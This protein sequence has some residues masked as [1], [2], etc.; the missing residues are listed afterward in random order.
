[1]RQIN[2]L[3]AHNRMLESDL[4]EALTRVRASGWLV[5]GPEVEAFEREFADYCGI[6]HCI[7][8]ASG[9]D[10][11]E[12]ALRGLGVGPGDEVITAPNAGMYSSVA[13]L[14]VGATP[15]YA[16]IDPARSTICPDDAATRITSRTRALI[17]THLYG[18]MAKVRELRD[19]AMRNGFPLIEDCAQAHGAT[20]DGVRAGAWGDAAAFSFYPTKNLG[21]LGDAGAVL[22]PLADVAERVRRLRQYGWSS[23]YFCELKGGRNSR[24]DEIQAAALRVK[25]CHLD[26]WNDRRRAVAHCYKEEINHCG[27]LPPEVG[28]TDYVAHLFVI[29][30]ERRR[31]LQA[32]LKANGIAWD[33]HYP[34][35]D[36]QQPALAGLLSCPSLAESEAAVS[37][38]LTLPCYPE[39]PLDAVRKACERINAWSGV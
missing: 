13:I 36:Y 8:V 11:L 33:V 21:A 38:I 22:T 3:L 9:S 35:L 17:A 1:M 39:L 15:V 4:D 18:R 16:D 19:V 31:G 23:K 7:G 20:L 12:L 10:A 32:F 28:G 34:L 30:A 25:L 26:A 24:L 5:L 27:I 14:A 29:R 37:R 6:P 2:D